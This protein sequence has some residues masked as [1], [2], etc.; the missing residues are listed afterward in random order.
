MDVMRQLLSFRRGEESFVGSGIQI[1]E[2]IQVILREVQFQKKSGDVRR[3]RSFLRADH[4]IPNQ[5]LA[6]CRAHE[7]KRSTGLRDWQCSVCSSLASIDEA[8]VFDA[9][10]HAKDTLAEMFKAL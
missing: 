8:L 5:T 9:R 10:R 3:D 4:T 2:P 6:H 7:L 1:L